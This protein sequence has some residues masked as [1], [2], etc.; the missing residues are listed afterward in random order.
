VVCDFHLF[1]RIWVGNELGRMQ[2]LGQ[3]FVSFVRQAMLQHEVGQERHNLWIIQIAMG[4]HTGRGATGAIVCEHGSFWGA[5]RFDVILDEAALFG[6]E[7]KACFFSKAA[8]LVGD[9]DV[10]VIFVHFV[11]QLSRA[12]CEERILCVNL[13]VKT[14]PKCAKIEKIT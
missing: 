14:I 3:D 1:A 10:V 9:G 2:G 7:V 11:L 12:G 8:F 5:A 6:G 13:C 4:Q